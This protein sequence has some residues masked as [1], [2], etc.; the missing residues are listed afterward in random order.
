[1]QL[2]AQRINEKDLRQQ[3]RRER[4]RAETRHEFRERKLSRGCVVEACHD[5][6]RK[7]DL[8]IARIAAVRHMALQRGNLGEGL[9]LRSSKYRHMS[10]SE[11]D[12]SFPNMSSGASAMAT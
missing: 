9:K 6:F 4:L 11:I 8:H 10:S 3:I 2:K 12:M 5:L 7:L 1:L